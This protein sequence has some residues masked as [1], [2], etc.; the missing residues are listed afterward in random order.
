MTRRIY[1]YF[2]L[3]FL[4][5]V[6]AGGAAGYF[7]AWHAPGPPRGFDPNRIVRHMQKDLNLSDP[8]VQQ[9]AQILS[10]AGKKYTN[11]QKQTEPEFAAIREESRNRIRQVLTPEQVTKFNELIRRVDE[12]R[13]QRRP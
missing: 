8:Q 11:L 10:D 7:Y 6:I 3:T 5:G 9:V 13:R 2:S 12:R 1:L 4:L